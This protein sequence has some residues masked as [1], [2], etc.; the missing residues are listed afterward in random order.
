M[1]ILLTSNVLIPEVAAQLGVTTASS[2]GWIQASTES[3]R[4]YTSDIT[5]GI[6]T[7]HPE[8]ARRGYTHNDIT[9][10]VIQNDVR[11][12]TRP[13]HRWFITAMRD[14]INDFQPD[15]IHV[16]GSEYSYGMAVKMAR[17]DIPALLSIQG[18]SFIWRNVHQRILPLKERLRYD[19]LRDL[20]SLLVMRKQESMERK[21][22][23][24]FS[25]ICGR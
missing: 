8:L 13:P 4:R 1:K 24:S 3:L 20:A 15:V 9:H 22:I 17:P 21:T 7:T 14:I 23:A 5:L 19:T 2:G 12:M 16:N 11:S 18:I 6:V 25:H 10:Y